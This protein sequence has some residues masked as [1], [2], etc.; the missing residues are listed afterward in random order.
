MLETL[1]EEQAANQER[2][3]DLEKRYVNANVYVYGSH[4]HAHTHIRARAHT[5]TRV[6]IHMHECNSVVSYVCHMLVGISFQNT[7]TASH[8]AKLRL[9]MPLLPSAVFLALMP[10]V[11][12]LLRQVRRAWPLRLN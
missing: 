3:F 10:A 11:V 8:K 7:A 1:Q 6:L 2:L 5:H 12:I 4:T 9:S